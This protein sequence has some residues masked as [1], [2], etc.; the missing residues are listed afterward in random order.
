M[1]LLS[2]INDLHPRRSQCA[3]HV[4]LGDPADGRIATHFRSVPPRK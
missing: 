3:A 2:H 1:T 4:L